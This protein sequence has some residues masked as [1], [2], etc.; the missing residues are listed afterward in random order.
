MAHITCGGLHNLR[1]ITP[2]GFEFTDPLPV[3]DI[4]AFIQEKGNVD[5]KEM[6]KTFNMGMGYVII[7]AKEDAG[8][9][10]KMTDGKIVGKVVKSGCTIRGIKLW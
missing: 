9:I 5:D 10:V 6:Y 2:Y 4:F 8:A 7:C 3:P 1:R